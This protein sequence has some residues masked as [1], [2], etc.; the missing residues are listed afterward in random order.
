MMG[1]LL[2][3]CFV[4]LEMHIHVSVYILVGYFKHIEFFTNNI[5]NFKQQFSVSFRMLCLSY[6]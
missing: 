5:F 6:G 2:I 4:L 1:F 3:F